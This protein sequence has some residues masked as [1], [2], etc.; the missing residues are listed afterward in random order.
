MAEADR[1]ILGASNRNFY[2][3]NSPENFA[4]EYFS[5]FDNLLSQKENKK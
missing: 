4:K 1:D 3:K 5:L 2:E